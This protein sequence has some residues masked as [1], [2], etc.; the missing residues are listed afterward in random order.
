M[1]AE[2]RHHTV[3]VPATSA[4]LGAGYDA[5]GLAV[6][7]HLAVR[8]RPCD[9]DLPRV[10]ILDASV[11]ELADGDDNLIWRAFVALC[12]HAEVPVPDLGLD[13]H[14]A[15]PLERGLGSSSSAI[16]AGVALARAVLDLPLSATSLIEVAAEL[17]GHPD[18]VAPAMLGGV[19]ACVSTSTG[20]V[21]RRRNPTPALRPVLMIPRT[22]QATAEARGVVP[23]HLS[24]AQV[25]DQAARAGHVL[26]ALTGAWPLDARTAGDQLHEP[27]RLAAMPATG[28]LLDAV[29]ERGV[30]AW[31]SG[32]GP[33]AL[34]MI[35]SHDQT[36]LAWL[37]Q[38]GGEHGFEVEAT[39]IE[40][41]GART[42]PDDG[43]GLGGGACLQCPRERLSS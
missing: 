43:C 16:V 26:A 18:N 34:A 41:S 13:A 6:D 33:T 19:V 29:R 10:R 14:S 1:S 39:R 12:E 15:I 42:C 5:F 11:T 28:A 4:N 21:V 7:R 17:E 8:T 2:V 27:A 37:M 9:D 20:L 24:R 3:Q 30:H 35:A 36:T 31:L 23:E 38:V 22:R 40:L 25:A 32:A